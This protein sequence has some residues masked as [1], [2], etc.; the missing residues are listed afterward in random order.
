MYTAFSPQPV[1]GPWTHKPARVS[2]DEMNGADAPGAAE[3][4]AVNLREADRAPDVAFNEILWKL[5]RGRN[6]VM[7]PPVHAGWVRASAAALAG[8]DDDDDD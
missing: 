3:S 6:A 7:P 1:A 5:V 4:A 8:D 2:I